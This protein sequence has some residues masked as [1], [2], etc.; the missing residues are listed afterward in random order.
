[1][2]KKQVLTAP[3]IFFGRNSG[4]SAKYQFTFI[5]AKMKRLSNISFFSRPFGK[6]LVQL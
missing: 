3:G 6:D 5:N 2:T 4:N 1:M